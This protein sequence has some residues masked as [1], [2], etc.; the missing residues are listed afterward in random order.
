MVAPQ[1]PGQAGMSLRKQRVGDAVHGA[2]Q[3]TSVLDAVAVAH[4]TIVATA[5]IGHGSM[6]IEDR[7]KP[8]EGLNVGWQARKYHVKAQAPP[9]TLGLWRWPASASGMQTACKQEQVRASEGLT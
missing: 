8:R 9:H 6:Q 2:C 1:R 4:R 7:S 3:Q 5:D